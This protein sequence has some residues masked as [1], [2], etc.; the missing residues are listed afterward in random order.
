MIRLINSRYDI[1]KVFR[2]EEQ[3]MRK[4]KKYIVS[5]K[6][7]K[8]IKAKI[9]NIIKR[10][11]IKN[12]VFIIIEF[13]SMLFFFYFVTAFCEVYYN[14]Q[15]S[16]LED[17]VGSF[18]L[19][20]ILELLGALYISVLYKSSLTYKIECLFNLVIFIHKII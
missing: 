9:E 19:S 7:R 16:W 3:K 10:L 20:F 11:K 1:E 5:E 15:S 18:F 4:N 17:S 6:N 14:T 2:R 8:I 12:I 13:L